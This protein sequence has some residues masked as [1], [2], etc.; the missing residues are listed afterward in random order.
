MENNNSEGTA[1]LINMENS[2]LLEPQLV[3]D[4]WQSYHA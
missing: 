3:T 4:L 1:V 2:G